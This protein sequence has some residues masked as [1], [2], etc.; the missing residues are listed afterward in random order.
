MSKA[1]IRSKI[2]S[3]D[4]PTQP[5]NEIFDMCCEV[6]QYNSQSR[7]VEDM[8]DQKNLWIKMFKGPMCYDRLSFFV[9]ALAH[10]S[11]MHHG[12]TPLCLQHLRQGS[13]EVSAE[14]GQW[15]LWDP[16]QDVPRAA[17]VMAKKDEE[18]KYESKYLSRVSADINRALAT[19]YEP[20]EESAEDLDAKVNRELTPARTSTARQRS[21]SNRSQRKGKGWTKGFGKAERR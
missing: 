8:V 15:R 5:S 6:A 19:R 9:Q 4:W 7:N 16:P 3:G 21:K 12:R 10:S 17:E 18:S 2:N 14:S 11:L 20:P 13:G 1:A